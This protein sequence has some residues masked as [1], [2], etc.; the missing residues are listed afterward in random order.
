MSKFWMIWFCGGFIGFTLSLFLVY[1]P[2]F[3]KYEKKELHFVTQIML[4]VL[5]VLLGWI[6]LAFTVIMFTAL[7]DDLKK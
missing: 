5:C 2:Y 6:S 4:F 3:K 7:Y 1:I